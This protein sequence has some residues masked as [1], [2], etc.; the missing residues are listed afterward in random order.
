ML[1]LIASLALA[2]PA[3][4][5]FEATFEVAYR[6]WRIISL[7]DGPR[8]SYHPTCSAFARQALVRDG[9]LGI[10][11]VFDRLLREP[12]A[13]RYPLHE[14]HVHHAD[15]LRRHVRLRDVFRGCRRQ[16]RRGAGACPH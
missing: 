14:D 15:P 16:R 7:A 12:V 5:P 13:R 2:G 10:P 3:L 4:D 6:G 11:L 1:G 9:P 8:C